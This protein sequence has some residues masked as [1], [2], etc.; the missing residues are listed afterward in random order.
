MGL[1]FWVVSPDEALRRRWR[2][3][4]GREGWETRSGAGLEA[5]AG[6][7][8]GP[9][10]LLLDWRAAGGDVPRAVRELKRRRPRLTVIVS[11]RETLPAEDVIAALEAGAD[12]H[13]AAAL[14]ERLFVAKLRAH[15]RRLSPGRDEQGLLRSPGGGLVLDRARREA[16]VRGRKGTAPVRG[17]TPREFE[18]LALFLERPGRVIG[19]RDILETLWR[20][21]GGAVRPGTVDKHVESLRRKLGRQGALIRTV[22]GVG[23]ALREG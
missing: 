22:Y 9:C 2:A 19:R 12:D 1:L 10:V 18:L 8:P 16:R 15:A 17:L 11:E 23:Y 14:S 5:L 13:F 7:V 21:R 6:A 4:L 3:W 20:E